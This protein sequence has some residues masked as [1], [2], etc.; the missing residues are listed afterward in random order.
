MNSSV[1]SQASGMDTPKL[2]A[3]IVLAVGAIAGFYYFSDQSQLVRVIGMLVVMGVAVAIAA[4]TTIG[5]N[6][7]SFASA[8][9]MEVRKVV[10][11]TRAETMQATLAVFFTVIVLGVFM[12]VLDLLLL[13]AVR[14]LTG[15]GG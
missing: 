6:A 1:D 13:W 12:W 3:A 14:L 8:S 7:I 5:R 10:W 15:Q 2:L 11:P 9:R 4:T